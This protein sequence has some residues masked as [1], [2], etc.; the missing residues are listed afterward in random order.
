MTKT[1]DNPRRLGWIRFWQVYFGLDVALNILALV[2]FVKS[3]YHFGFQDYIDYSE[4]ICSGV[5]FWLI[6]QRKRVTRYVVP[7][8]TILFV[9]VNFIGSY[10]FA[11]GSFDF[12]FFLD[13]F[14]WLRM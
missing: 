5:I 14:I 11:G 12:L 4:V 13:P 9:V 8:V 1:F 2:L 6:Y 3:S 7:V 10:S